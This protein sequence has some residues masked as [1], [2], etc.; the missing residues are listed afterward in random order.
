MRRLLGHELVHVIQQD[1][2]QES[3]IRRYTAAECTLYT[4][5][6]RSLL[7]TYTTARAI[8]AGSLFTGRFYAS[9]FMQQYLD[10]ISNDA[11][12]HFNDFTSNSGGAAALTYANNP[13]I[14]KK[15]KLN[16]FSR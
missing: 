11:Y 7:R 4:C 15:V 13:V 6:D 10:G 8:V 14:F 2:N 3:V 1:G 16:W 12:V 5:L 9:A